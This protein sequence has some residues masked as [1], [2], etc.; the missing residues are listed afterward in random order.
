MSPGTAQGRHLKST[1]DSFDDKENL[2]SKTGLRQ[3]WSVAGE[4]VRTLS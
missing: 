3:L 1:Q 4:G 2:V